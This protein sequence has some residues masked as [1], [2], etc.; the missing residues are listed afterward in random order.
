[1]DAAGNF[2]ITW[3]ADQT[4]GSGFG[5]FAQRFDA[6]AN[7]RGTAIAINAVTN[8]RQIDARVGMDSTGEFVVTWSSF[9]N[10]ANGFDIYARRF[11][12]AGVA[13]DASEFRV[14]KTVAQP[15]VTPDIEMDGK[16]DF[17]IVWSAFDQDNYDVNN[18]TSHDNGI[19]AA[20]YNIKSATP[21]LGEYRVNATT[22]GDQI[23]PAIAM[24]AAGDCTI[25]WTGPAGATTGI[26]E[27]VIQVPT[28]F[29]KTVQAAAVTTTT[30]ATPSTTTTS[31][32]ATTTTPTGP[33]TSTTTTTPA[34]SAATTTTPA[35]STTTTGPATSTTSRTALASRTSIIGPAK[36]TSTATT[37]AAATTTTTA[38]PATTTTTPAATTTTTATPA[39]TTTTPAAATTTTTTAAPA[40]TTTT[41]AATTTTTTAA[42]PATT[43]TDPGCCDDND[44]DGSSGHYHDDAGG[45]VD[46]NYGATL[47]CDRALAED[48]DQYDNH[49]CPGH[50]DDYDNCG[51]GHY[52]NV[53]GDNS[54]H[55]GDDNDRGYHDCY[56]NHGSGDSNVN[57]SHSGDDDNHADSGD[58][59][60]AEDD[61]EHGHDFKHYGESCRSRPLEETISRP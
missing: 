26:Y 51:S 19:Y 37:P 34:A 52:P 60:A 8:D 28:D 40:T 3:A 56:D 12:A 9:Q 45:D 7:K 1:M 48:D 44:D 61:D 59:N 10:A 23:A 46:D 20:M 49:D 14:N 41:P 21:V 17:V 13:L 25:A 31:T 32:A 5:I 33:A 42:T 16:G 30:T 6:A 39:T 11:S 4:D 29:Y 22:V 18:V 38:A 47:G 57:A 55:A 58:N 27:R 2:I 54:N 53:D 36:S 35:A 50:H 15:Q 24:D 43:T